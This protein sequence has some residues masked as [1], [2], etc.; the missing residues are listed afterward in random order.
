MLARTTAKTNARSGFAMPGLRGPAFT[1]GL[2]ATLIYLFGPVPMFLATAS[3]F[4]T[5]AQLTSSFFMVFLTAGVTS[6]ILS[7]KY[8]QPIGTGWAGPGLIYMAAVSANYTYGELAGAT[9]LAALITVALAATGLVER[10]A[11]AMP[12]PVVLAV[13]AGSSLH[14][15]TQGVSALK[16]EPWAVG[17]MITVFFIARQRPVSWAP[18]LAMACGAGVFILAAQGNFAASDL[19]FGAPTLEFVTPAFSLAAVTGL[20]LPLV[21]LTV[22]LQSMQGFAV[23]RGAGYEPP[24]R[25]T[26]GV[27]GLMGVAHAFVGGPPAGMQTTPLMVMAAEGVGPRES[28]WTA[29]IVASVGCLA[30]AGLA[31]TVASFVAALPFAFVAA[32]LGIILLTTVFDSLRAALSG[33]MAFPAF[34]AF[35]VAASDLSVGGIGAPLWGLAAGAAGAWHVSGAGR[36]TSLEAFRA[37]RRAA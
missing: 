27:L 34:I 5:P 11:K 31:V 24:V 19:R 3:V 14:F 9:L 2:T 4:S 18:P 30:I 12:V 35:I 22:G 36:I 7:L 32:A 25:A 33:P 20:A 23:L 26:S 17:A 29:A 15:L 10:L 1:A 6:I 37:I 13:V 21:L 16:I 28:R 8:R